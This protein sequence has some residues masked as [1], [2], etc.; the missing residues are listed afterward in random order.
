MPPAN[1]SNNL[2][3]IWRRLADTGAKVIW[4]TTTPVLFQHAPPDCRYCRNE[5]SVVQYNSLALAA[6]TE[7][8]ASTPNT[9]LLVNDVW[10]DVINYCGANYS[11]CTLQLAGGVHFTQMGRQYTG[12]SAAVSIL[13]A[14]YDLGGAHPRNHAAIPHTTVS[15]AVDLSAS[16]PLPAPAPPKADDEPAD[17]PRPKCGEPPAALDPAVPNVLLIGDSISMGYSVYKD[18]LENC[19][20]P[21]PDFRF[22]ALQ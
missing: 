13:S 9:R 2:Q 8:A 1:Y 11:R 15:T 20:K 19:T 7:A 17:P 10:A 18:Q 4:R 14:L 21:R 16:V 5:S 22:F 3:Y 6:L 12:F